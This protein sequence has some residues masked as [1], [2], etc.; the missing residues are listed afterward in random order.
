M[1]KLDDFYKKVSKFR[2]VGPQT[3]TN[4]DLKEGVLENAGDLFNNLHYIYKEK[5]ESEKNGLNTKY[6][7]KYDYQ[8]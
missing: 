1:K 3:K 7:K 6:R 8:K 2:K 4:E 5:F